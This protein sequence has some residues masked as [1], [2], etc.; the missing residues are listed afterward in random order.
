MT[1]TK[2]APK[3]LDAIRAYYHSEAVSGLIRRQP[4]Y[5][6]HYLLESVEHPGE[7]RSLTA[8]DRREDAEVYERSGVYGELVR[9]FGQWLT[10]PPQVN[11]YEVRE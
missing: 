9:Q 2:V 10:I 4:G 6:F 7:I 11:S 8:W 5:R 1:F 3:D